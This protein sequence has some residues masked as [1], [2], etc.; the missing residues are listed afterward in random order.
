MPRKGQRKEATL[1]RPVLPLSKSHRWDGR[2]SLSIFK[3]I[4]LSRPGMWAAAIPNLQALNSTQFLA[5]RYQI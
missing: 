4:Q 5:L 2:V 3:Y 1:S